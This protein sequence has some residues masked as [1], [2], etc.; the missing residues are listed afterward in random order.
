MLIGYPVTPW[1]DVHCMWKLT[2]MASYKQQ[3][4]NVYWNIHSTFCVS[5]GY[6][7][8]S[9]SNGHLQLFQDSI[10]YF[11]IIDCLQLIVSYAYEVQQMSSLIVN[12]ITLYCKTTWKQK[13]NLFRYLFFIYIIL[14]NNGGLSLPPS[15]TTGVGSTI[16]CRTSC[17][18]WFLFVRIESLS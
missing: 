18:S 4:R 10:W 9:F 8:K 7:F 3:Q 2:W 13:K 6:N 11:N 14:L 1:W 16:S 5:V 15:F 12:L 17:P